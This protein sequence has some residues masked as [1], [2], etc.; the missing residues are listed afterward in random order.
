MT[1]TLDIIEEAILKLNGYIF[2]QYYPF[3]GS[4]G[5]S[6]T[7][8]P[9]SQSNFVVMNIHWIIDTALASGGTTIS[10]QIFYQYNGSDRV[11]WTSIFSEF[12]NDNMDDDYVFTVNGTN[13]ISFGLSLGSLNLANGYLL[14]E[15]IYQ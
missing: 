5:L 12:I 8:T 9:T 1:K 4:S 2:S 6:V 3:S 11:R 7:I 10:V 13:N 15:G 14:V